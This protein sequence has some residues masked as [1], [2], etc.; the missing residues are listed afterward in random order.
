MRRRSGDLAILLLFLMFASVYFYD[1]FL[2]YVLAEEDGI[3]LFLPMNFV[4]REVLFSGAFPLWNPYLFSGA[5]LL[6]AID[7]GVLY[8]FNLVQ[9][10][11][12]SPFDGFNAGII[13]SYALAGF[14]TFLFA[15]LIGAGS[16]PAFVA[17]VVFAFLGF[18]KGNV[19]HVSTVNSGLWLPLILYFAE[20]LR[21]TLRAR[22]IA[23]MALA[24][25]MQI[26]AGGSQITFYSFVL[27][28]LYITFFSFK[29][30]RDKRLH[31]L[32]S[33][34]AALCLAILISLPHLLAGAEFMLRSV[35]RAIT[36]EFFT[37]YKFL[38]TLIPTVL[39]PHVYV[40]E[41]L[42]WGPDNL[43]KTA[44]MLVSSLPVLLSV[45]VWARM[46]KV[47]AQVMFWGLAGMVFFALALHTPLQKL[48]YHAPLFNLFRVVGRN[49]YPVDFSLSVLTAL[50]L[51]YVMKEREHAR[52]IAT[53]F[54]TLALGILGAVL[55][56]ALLGNQLVPYL[57]R[58]HFVNPALVKESA[59]L[60]FR[61]P[62]IYVPCIFISLYALWLLSSIMVR[63][64]AILYPLLMAVLAAEVASYR[65]HSP[66]GH[67]VS[68]L[69]FSLRSLRLYNH[70]Y[71]DRPNRVAFYVDATRKALEHSAVWLP[72]NFPQILRISMLDGYMPI[73]D[74]NY[75]RLLD[76]YQGGVMKSWEELIENNRILSMLNVKHL[77]VHEMD[78]EKLRAIRRHGDLYQFLFS[79][80]GYS[81]FLNTRHL[82]RAYSVA[83]VLP[84]RSSEETRTLFSKHRIDPARQAAVED[85]DFQ[86]LKHMQ[87]SFAEISLRSYDVNH[88]EMT[89]TSPGT[90][91]LV[92]ADQYYPGWLARI[93][94]EETEIFR[95][96][97]VVRGVVIPSGEHTVTFSYRPR[98]IYA[99]LL[100]SGMSMLLCMLVIV[101]RPGQGRASRQEGET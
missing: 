21:R 78:R 20:L 56:A 91:F 95:T 26:V 58:L 27:A 69:V 79:E 35:R 71:Q 92:L 50:G 67:E 4:I 33:C 77:I 17:G 8:P 39:F 43:V 11:F 100:V 7:F 2:G 23:L 13:L 66:L 81:V 48:L 22:H 94:G 41:G 75:H 74:R 86:R 9:H 99:S 3:S 97:G 36:Y 55:L 82:P 53:A 63:K 93:D 30:E 19:N 96:N 88:V 72:P 54:M 84:V 70:L 65:P 57:E 90:S 80:L 14:F 34:V 31:F 10:V 46:R 28:V 87:F 16:V 59:V 61:N 24:I 47:D 85:K 83:E 89:V 15:R 42:Y 1:A 5:P 60:S 68:S 76:I 73:I 49:V 38:P 6:G 32:L 37:A 62:A 45:A 51:T 29:L 40:S 25:A 101:R 98:K 12:P 44:G 64:K 18:L 52:R